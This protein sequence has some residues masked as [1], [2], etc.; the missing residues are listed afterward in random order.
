MSFNRVSACGSEGGICPSFRCLRTRL[1]GSVPAHCFPF[2]NPS[3]RRFPHILRENPDSGASRLGRVQP[4]IGNEPFLLTYGD[5][6]SNVNIIFAYI[7]LKDE[8]RDLIKWAWFGF[9]GFIILGV[10]FYLAN[11]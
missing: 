10:A 1:I 3:P 4:H 8:R 11:R 6:V 9:A 5:G 7:F 2:T